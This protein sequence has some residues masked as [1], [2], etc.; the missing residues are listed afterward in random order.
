MPPTPKLTANPGSNVATSTALDSPF[1]PR[2]VDLDVLVCFLQ[3]A[4]FLSLA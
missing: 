1:G 2:M 3:N 4:A